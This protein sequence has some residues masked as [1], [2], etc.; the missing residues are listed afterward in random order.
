MIRLFRT[1]AAVIVC[2]FLSTTAFV[3]DEFDLAPIGG[4]DVSWVP[5]RVGVLLEADALVLK[6]EDANRELTERLLAEARLPASVA[7]WA[8]NIGSGQ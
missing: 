6:K 7:G 4:D 8:K 1:I 5:I 3:Q 2:G